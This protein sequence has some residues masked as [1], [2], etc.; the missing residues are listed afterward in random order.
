[1]IARNGDM[2]CDHCGKA[3]PQEESRHTW[4]GPVPAKGEQPRHYHLDRK[5]PA[6][7]AAGGITM[8]PPGDSRFSQFTSAV[9]S[10]L[11]ASG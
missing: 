3:I 7:R 1:M 4:V 6:C 2:I 10:G 11:R 9:I 5:Y 8:N